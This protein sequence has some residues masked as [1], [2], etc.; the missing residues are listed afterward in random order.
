MSDPRPR[1]AATRS[2]VAAALVIGCALLTWPAAAVSAATPPPGAG[3]GPPQLVFP[4]T[5]QPS[6]MRVVPAARLPRFWADGRRCS[7][8][9]RPRGAIDGWPLKPFHRQHALRAGLNEARGSNFHRGID[10]QARDGSRVYAMQGGYAEVLAARGVDA[11]VR[12][13]RYIYWHIRPHVS[14]GQYVRPYATVVGTVLATA[15]HLHLSELDPAD[16]CRYLNPLRPGGRVLRPWRDTAPPLIGAP[17]FGP[18]GSVTVKAFDPQSFRVRTT[19]VTPVLAPAALAYRV[20]GAH[21]R[22]VVPRRWALRGSQ[23]LPGVPPGRLYAPGS[24]PAGWGC[25]MSHVYCRPNW[26]YRLAG[27]PAPALPPL[28]PGGYLLT[29]YAWDWAGNVAARDARFIVR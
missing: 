27:G 15:G 17:R 19:Y 25:H 5:V 24:R 10:I 14:S 8:G 2:A 20:V 29:V 22:V 4:F 13:G 3:P 6:A 26:H 9:C 7:V 23:H 21:G 1:S 28:R 11:R 18:L 12:V 16:P